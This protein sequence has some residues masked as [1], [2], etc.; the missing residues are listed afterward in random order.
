MSSKQGT[1]V[2]FYVDGADKHIAAV[3]GVG[4]IPS[5]GDL[6]NI[7]GKTYRVLSITWAVDH[8]DEWA[9]TEL[10]ANMDIELV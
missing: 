6:V 8:S 2:E 4:A 7:R 9:E 3:S 5:T 10:R 1:R